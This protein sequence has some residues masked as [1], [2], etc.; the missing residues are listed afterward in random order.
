M[1]NFQEPSKGAFIRL[2]NLF[3]L[4]SLKAQWPEERGSKED[5]SISVLNSLSISNIDDFILS[6]FGSC[7]QHIYVLA[8]NEHVKSFPD[9]N[10]S[11]AQKISKASNEKHIEILFLANQEYNVLL[12]NPWSEETLDFLWPI[13]IDVYEKYLTIKFVTLEK[14]ISS[15][16]GGETHFVTDKSLS[17]RGIINALLNHFKEGSYPEVLDLHAGVKHLWDDDLVD[18]I[19]VNYKKS[20]SKASEAMDPDITLK[21]S[22][23]D[24]YAVVSES[25]L[26]K[27]LLKNTGFDITGE[28]F[29]VDPG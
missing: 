27:T 28:V 12:K 16:I 26:Y 19:R 3:P 22:D 6:H 25:P 1:N 18:S 11:F 9:I 17:E 8:H 13:K 2:L 14:K 5:I 10:F 21:Q 15:Y 29:S 20:L 23:P 24:L 7:K 4:R